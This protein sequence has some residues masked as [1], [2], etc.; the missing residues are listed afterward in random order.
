MAL[1][2]QG[3]AAPTDGDFMVCLSLAVSQE[4]LHRIQSSARDHWQ[5]YDIKAISTDT[6]SYVWATL[7]HELQRWPPHT[8]FVSHSLHAWRK[9]QSDKAHVRA[10]VTPEEELASLVPIKTAELLLPG[11]DETTE[12]RAERNRDQQQ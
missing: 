7:L 10:M 5:C 6:T 9:G 1:E 3:S 12:S 2:R 11:W 8:P 4:P